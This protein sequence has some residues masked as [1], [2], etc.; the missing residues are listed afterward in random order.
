MISNTIKLIVSFSIVLLLASLGG[1]TTQSP[2]NGND[3]VNGNANVNDNVNGNAND[4]DNDNGTPD[5][6]VGDGDFF[7]PAPIVDALQLTRTVTWS[8][9]SSAPQNLTRFSMGEGGGTDVIVLTDSGGSVDANLSVVSSLASET[10][11]TN[12][13]LLRSMFKFIEHADGSFRIV[14]T[15]HSNYALD[16]GE[17]DTLIL[18]DVR[19]S[20]RETSTAAYLT[21]GALTASPMILTATGRKLYDSTSEEFED[22]S[23]WVTRQVVLT[24]GVLTLTTADGTSMVFYSAPINLDIPFDFNPDETARVSNPEVKFESSDDDPFARIPLDIAA[25]YADQVAAIGADAGTAAA[26]LLM[27]TEIETSLADEGAQLRYPAAFYTAF[28]EGLFARRVQSSDSSNGVLD[29]HSVPYVYF[30][31]E[32]DG[33]GVHHPFMVVTSYGVP[34]GLALLW[35]VARPPGDGTEG[36]EYEQQSVTRAYHRENFH[37]KIPMRDYGEVESLTENVMINDLASDVNVTEL[38]HHNYASISATGLAIDGVVIYPS[39]NNGLHVSQSAA[40][41]SAHGMHSGRGLGVHYH[42]DAHSAT[43]DGL[44]LYNAEDYEGHSHPPIVSI[45]FDGVAGYGVYQD[46]DF[47]SDGAGIAL[48]GFG[49]HEHGA[50]AYH[51]HSFTIAETTPTGAGPEDPAGG[52][53]YT[54]HQLP[55]LGAWGGRI[56]DI[57]EFWDGPAPNLVGDHTSVYLGFE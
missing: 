19:S 27:I 2:D 9:L 21:F 49:G 17:L 13:L 3:N 36:T 38:D 56:N 18:R 51:Y 7:A 14:S 15:K 28:R 53:S 20:S 37:M 34:D 40:E 52:V 1:C 45:G 26:A 32:A 43:G 54:A 55:P 16:L 24:N 35:D 29:Q 23:S 46:G 31:N 39:Y 47:S 6:T 10:S 42:A 48:D 8:A 44:N 25:A 22:D 57:P 30:T 4:N 33:Q 12:D 50:Y 11:A 41:L 5:D